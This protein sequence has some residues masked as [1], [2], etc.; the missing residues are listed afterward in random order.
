[1]SPAGGTQPIPMT[2][3]SVQFDISIYYIQEA[4][5]KLYSIHTKMSD[6]MWFAFS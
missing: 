3:S 2:H 4:I 5:L 1:M 6:L